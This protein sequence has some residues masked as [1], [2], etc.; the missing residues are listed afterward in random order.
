MLPKYMVGIDS[1][2]EDIK[3]AEMNSRKKTA[4]LSKVIIYFSLSVHFY[5][6]WVFWKLL[7]DKCIK[8]L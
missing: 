6:F 2:D 3:K 4:T 7:K 1:L 5:T 8:L